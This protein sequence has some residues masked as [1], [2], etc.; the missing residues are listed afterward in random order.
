LAAEAD[1]LEMR[2]AGLRLQR[3]KSVKEDI[4]YVKSQLD[5]V[6]SNFEKYPT[7]NNK[8]MGEALNAMAS[9]VEPYMT[10][11]Q[12]A[13]K[14]YR[15]PEGVERPC[16]GDLVLINRLG[17][18][19]ATVIE[20]PAQDDEN[21]LVQ[22]GSLKL[23]AKLS[24]VAKV[25]RQEKVKSRKCFLIS[26][27]CF[28]S[29]NSVIVLLVSFYELKDCILSHFVSHQHPQQFFSWSIIVWYLKGEPHSMLQLQPTRKTKKLAH[30]F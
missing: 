26:H 24:E 7:G 30:M 2:L 19:L 3:E 14:K 8:S 20:T 29:Q 9:I 1:G 11:Y 16:V 23:R 28:I 5:E 21:F 6:V 18:N 10:K 17:R 15:R 13:E 25:I 22:L 27:V 12:N 4:N